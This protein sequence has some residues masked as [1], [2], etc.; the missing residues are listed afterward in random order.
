MAAGTKLFSF[1]LQR[2]AFF[3]KM[4]NANYLVRR[5]DIVP[6]TVSVDLGYDFL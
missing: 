4:V 1:L 6:A 3:C 5:F 2:V